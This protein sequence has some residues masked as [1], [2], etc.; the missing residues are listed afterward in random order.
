MGQ[1]GPDDVAGSHSRQRIVTGTKQNCTDKLSA[2]VLGSELLR[3]PGGAQAD[4]HE[5][6]NTWVG[7][8]YM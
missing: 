7:L 2:L 5:L 3:S 6:Q 8:K 4:G 1:N